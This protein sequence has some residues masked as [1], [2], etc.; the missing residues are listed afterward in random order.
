[1]RKIFHVRSN[2]LQHDVKKS[3]NR[4]KFTEFSITCS[5]TSFD[6]ST[7]PNFNPLFISS[8]NLSSEI[9]LWKGCGVH[10][11][12]SSINIVFDQPPPKA[13]LN[14]T[15]CE[16]VFQKKL[17]SIFVVLPSCHPFL[18]FVHRETLLLLI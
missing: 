11:I 15:C 1:M 18:N 13:L 14:F 7:T 10:K 16:S 17:A 4:K 5:G 8:I 3:G 9:G 6:K 2:T 12:N